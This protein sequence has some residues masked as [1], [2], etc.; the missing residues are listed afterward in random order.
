M[1]GHLITLSR[2]E[3]ER[4]RS[5]DLVQDGRITLKE[6]SRRMGLSYRQALR[7]YQSYLA[8]G[9]AGLA[10]GNRGRA[11]GRAYPEAF[12]AKVVERYDERY[13][14]LDMGPTLS[15]EKLAEQGMHVDHDTLRRWL[16]EAGSWKK[17]RRKNK[18]R[19]RR[20]RK[21][22]F[23]ELVQMDGS[24]H[25]WFGQEK[26]TA[27][28]MNMVDDATSDTLGWLDQQE[29]TD[30]AMDTL[31]LWIEKYGIPMALYTD[32]RTVYITD[33]EPTI[34]EQLANEQP[35]TFFGKACK[36]LGIEIIAAHSPQA[37]GRVE[38]S[39]GVYQDRFVKEL[40][41]RG[42]TTI[43][44]ANKLL[45]GGFVDDLNAKFAKEP[46]SDED[47]HRPVPDGLDLDD[48]FCYEHTRV[49]PNDW[50]VRHDNR[51][52]QILP[53]NAPLPRPKT[54]VTVRIRMD[55]TVHILCKG[56]RLNYETLTRSELKKRCEQNNSADNIHQLPP[57]NKQPETPRAASRRWRPNA[58]RM[59]AR[60]KD[61][62]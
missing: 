16:M 24:F 49:V 17:R 1:E 38:R 23:G 34:E 10:H 11:S 25:P 29:T 31:R 41:L 3:L 9:P 56:Q 62:K 53:D 48:V 28:L 12:K 13:K 33:R 54:K 32:K 21:H 57:G 6:A 45:T 59:I 42:I 50:V 51:H 20:E 47:W 61:K 55:K 43:D 2:K 39:N 8:Q 35:L 36:K 40:A 52:Y 4:K 22:H 5:L 44:T 19:S 15:A 60:M 26:D 46:I 27:C 7:V 18:H 58:G 14:A 37:K 30:A